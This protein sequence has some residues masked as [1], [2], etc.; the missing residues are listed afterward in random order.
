MRTGSFCVTAY[1]SLIALCA[2]PAAGGESLPSAPFVVRVY[3]EDPGE[4][5]A[6]M[7]YDLLEYNNRSERYV[8]LLVDAGDYRVLEAEGVR[9]E[10]DRLRTDSIDRSGVGT[11]TRGSGIPGYECYRTVEQTFNAA[12]QLVADRPDLATW[13]DVGD[14]WEKLQGSGG[15]DMSVLR[16]T[17][18]AIGGTKPKLMITS[19]IHA[20]EY[21]PAE[22]NTRFAEFLVGQYGV[23]ADATW[24]LDHHEIHLMLQGNP[25]G[26]KHAETG[27]L[28]RKNTNENYCGT[29]SPQRGADLNRNF[30]HDWG[31]CGGSSTDECHELYRGVAAASEPEV[32]VIQAY[33]RGIF[34][35]QRGDAPGAAAP[36]DATGVYLDVHSFGE[37]VLWPWGIPAAAPNADELQ[38]LGRKLAHFNGY[39]PQ[40]GFEL[41]VTDGTASDFG[42]GDLGLASYTLE[43]G[44]WFFEDC[45]GF[46]ATI[47]PDNLQSLIYAAKVARTPYLTPSGPDAFGVSVFPLIVD[48]GG[49]LSIAATIDDT[50]FN[51]SNGTEPTQNIAAAEYYVDVPPWVTSPMPLARTLTPLDGLLDSASEGVSASLDT[52]SLA[53]G[54]HILFLRGQDADGN[55]GAI[56]AAFFWVAD[57]TAGALRGVLTDVDTGLA[58]DGTVSVDFL[59]ASVESVPTL[60]S[61]ELIIPAGEWTLRATAPG[62]FDQVIEG[63]TVANGTAYDQD[64]ALLALPRILLVDDDGN[65]PDVAQSYTAALDALGKEYFLWET[66]EGGAEPDEA[67]LD[68]FDV[69]IWFSGARN[70]G[71]AGPGSAAETAVAGWLDGTGCLMVSSQD[72]H[73][74]SGL[75]PFMQDYLGAATVI[76]DVGQLIVTGQGAVFGQLGLLS[77]SYPYLNGSDAITADPTSDT[78]FSGFAGD[79]GL[80]KDAGHYR[81]AYWGFGLEALPTPLAREEAVEAF[82]DWCDPLPQL[83]GD[84]DGVANR[85]DCDPDDLNVWSL[86]SAARDLVVSNAASDNLTWVDSLDPGARAFS[87]DVLRS[88]DPSDFSAATC[89]AVGLMTTTATDTDVPGP[90]AVQYFLIRSSNGC[91]A[92][93][94]TDSRGV[95]RAGAP[96]F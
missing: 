15:Y 82:L 62:Y 53:G 32:Q 58:L 34:P 90:D 54:R 68:S 29:S 80:T 30:D 72:Y 42:Y 83:D 91:G 95:P 21:A 55:W 33:L 1:L 76:D 18:S 22:L 60:G 48:P 92:N 31:C 71:G 41:Y 52:T 57:G 75:T 26:R 89:S 70:D 27:V 40:Q 73:L 51:Q 8:L 47:L 36:L 3:Y 2:L 16:L 45:E 9:L 39:D 35:D 94:G 20:R 49:E 56:D 74:D 93:M 65:A 81:S 85:P 11:L 59:G 46:E 86:P 79:A 6:L 61:Y 50:R 25:D 84:G 78:A 24:L 17:N 19:S 63:F 10:V 67:S 28:W 44:S 23:D 87:Y 38:T 4:I 5:R 37:L 64:F 7:S 66:G 43:L 12:A 13:S 69:A 96:C 14:T 77:L 88:V